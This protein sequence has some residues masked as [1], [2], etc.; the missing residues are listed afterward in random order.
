MT[1]LAILYCRAC[2]FYGRMFRALLFVS[3]RRSLI[4]YSPEGVSVFT[5][6]Y[7]EKK[8]FSKL[9]PASQ[10]L[11]FLAT[12]SCRAASRPE[13]RFWQ[14]QL[15]EA[16]LKLLETKK[17]QKLDAAVSHLY[18][19]DP[20]AY[21]TLLETVETLSESCLVQRE[22]VAHDMLL[23][24]APVLAWTRFSIPYGPLSDAL[25]AGLSSALKEVVFAEDAQF[26][27]MQELFAIDQLPQS[28]AGVFSLMKKLRAFLPE[29]PAVLPRQETPSFLA[30]V[31]YLVIAVSAPV[32]R[33]M[34]RW[35]ES[36]SSAGYEKKRRRCLADWQKRAVPLLSGMMPG[37]VL[38]VMLPAAFFDACRKADQQIRPAS[39]HA[40][41]NYLTHAL[42]V[43]AADLRAVIGEFIE[44]PL[45]DFIAEYRIGFYLKDNPQ[46]LYGV[47][48]P[49]YEADEAKQPGNGTVFQ[50]GTGGQGSLVHILSA[51]DEAGV[52]CEKKHPERFLTEY[53][54]DCGGPLFADVHAELVHAELPESAREDTRLH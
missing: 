8:D 24:V 54:E 2:L 27:M 25:Y 32:S 41:V 11:I 49:V 19:A 14:R 39:I 22:G 38:D 30:D 5:M 48:W 28:H 50:E 52:Q 29:K 4:Q 44:A 21:E 18:Q 1:G 10:R 53:C 9:L 31:R 15:E 16:V 23:V 35:Q 37:C 33:P 51:L 3:G 7:P 13:Y 12:E 34:F 45:Q 36:A 40:A 42:D 47:V 26:V 43:D 17:Q 20:G 6:S 46:I